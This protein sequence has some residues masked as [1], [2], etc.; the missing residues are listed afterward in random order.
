MNHYIGIEIE[1][2]YQEWLQNKN[3]PSTRR[4]SIMDMAIAEYMKTRAAGQKLDP[5]FK[6]WATFQIR[7]FLFVGHDSA[8]VTIIFCLYQ[9]SK[10]PDILAKVR[11]EHDEV[12]GSYSA[13][14]LLRQHPEAINQLPYTSAVIKETLRLHPPANALRDGLPGMVLREQNGRAFPVE[15]FAIWALHG[16]IQRNA[17]SW[18]EPYEFIPEFIP[19]RWLVKPGHPLYPPNWGWRPFEQGPRNCVGQNMSLVSIKVSLLMT[20]REFN[21]HD[22][23]AEWDR[24]RLSAGIRAMDGERVYMVQKGSGHPAQ[25][26]PCK[27]TMARG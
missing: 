20:V 6:T 11:A 13:A 8:A 14:E 2:R 19:D 16:A 25:G 26:F 1:R 10:H 17:N 4:Q 5:E 21:V 27:V 7:L 3:K 24:L 22:Q 15:G 12:S 9:L 18:P 23:Y